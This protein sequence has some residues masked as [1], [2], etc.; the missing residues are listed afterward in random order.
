[1]A[2]FC[3]FIAGELLLVI[4]PLIAIIVLP[5]YL[6]GA[7]GF[8]FSLIIPGITHLVAVAAIL[9]EQ[10]WSLWYLIG[11]I[12]WWALFH[13]DLVSGFTNT[14]TGRVNVRSYFRQDGTYVRSHTRGYNYTNAREVFLGWC[15][16]TDNG[17]QEHVQKPSSEMAEGSSMAAAIIVV[18]GI[19]LLVI[20][21]FS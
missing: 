3:A 20:V 8:L 10:S 1:M 2:V 11:I 15:F 6:W 5:I 13:P 18:M 14:S 17:Q 19:L 16:S 7:W 9:H 12:V 4:T 21:I